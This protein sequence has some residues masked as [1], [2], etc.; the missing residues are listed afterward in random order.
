M[1]LGK[2]PV[3][4]YEEKNADLWVARFFTCMCCALLMQSHKAA[5]MFGNNGAE[6]ESNTKG[7][8]YRFSME[9]SHSGIHFV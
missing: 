9:G 6:T 1:R 5:K 8:R 3:F 4:M 7:S 2:V